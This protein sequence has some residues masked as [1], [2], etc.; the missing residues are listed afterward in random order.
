MNHSIS[1]F[2]F[3]FTLVIA[4]WHFAMLSKEWLK[5]GYIVVEFFFILSGFLLYQSSH[6]PIGTIEYTKNKLSKF[7]FKAAVITII[8]SL[9]S[10]SIA[11]NNL[12][13]FLQY[14]AKVL[15][16]MVDVVPFDKNIQLGNGPI[17]YLTVLIWGGTFIYAIIK[18]YPKKQKLILAIICFVCYTIV[19]NHS[20]D[21]NDVWAYPLP[22]L[23]GL[24]GISLGCIL[25]YIVNEHVN[26]HSNI[27]GKT[28][29]DITGILGFIISTILLFITDVHGILPVI[30][31]SFIIIACF[32]QNSAIS[33]MLN[34]PIFSKLA[35]TSFEI[36]IGHIFVTKIVFKIMQ[37]CC[38][39]NISQTIDTTEKVFGS[40]L[41]IITLF[42]F[43]YI[44]QKAC[45]RAQ[46][47][48]N[49]IF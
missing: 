14:T 20:Y 27:I 45:N 2:R 17:W 30:C 42:I 22:L 9:T 49:R 12:N 13:N 43:G 32:K 18:T 40:I 39:T 37:Y 36:F 25:N 24:A 33:K 28:L 44:Y 41:Y 38:G 29:I 7:W 8:I 1:F 26:E 46:K 10:G 11:F 16:L 15:L 19:L 21:L 6:K 4:F 31:Y 47:E 3:I 5:S 48:L 34:R 35:S 23:R